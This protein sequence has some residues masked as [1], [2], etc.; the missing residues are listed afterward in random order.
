M[1][2]SILSIRGSIMVYELCCEALEIF[3]KEKLCHFFEIVGRVMVLQN[4]LHGRVGLIV[5]VLGCLRE[6]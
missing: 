3:Y 2:V 1:L 4:P 6:L 5:N